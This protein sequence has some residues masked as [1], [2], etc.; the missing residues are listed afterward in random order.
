[1]GTFRVAPSVCSDDAFY[2]FTIARNAIRGF[3]FSFDRIAETNGFH[4]LWLSLILPIQAFV[5]DRILAIH[6]TLTLSALVDTTTIYILWKLLRERGVRQVVCEISCGLYA[7]AP[8]L[9]SHAGPMSGLETPLNLMMISYYLVLYSRA[10][11]FESWSVKQAA[12]FG[13]CSALLFLTRTDNGIL[14][15]ITYAHIGFQHRKQM[16]S[17]MHL[18]AS[19]LAALVLVAP[20]LA[21]SFVRFG[22]FV[23]VSGLSIAYVMRANLE[24]QGW[25]LADYFMQAFRN[26][27]GIVTF[28]PFYFYDTK[29]TSLLPL[30]LAS[31]IG[32]FIVSTLWH[33]TSNC[34]G[35]LSKLSPHVGLIAPLLAVIIAYVFV[36]TFRGVYLR[37]W[38]YT[39]FYPVLI[40]LTGSFVELSVKT[41]TK[42]QLRNISIVSAVLALFFYAESLGRV[43]AKERGER[44]KYQMVTSLNETLPENT[45]IGSWNAGVYGYFFDR[46]NVVNLDGLVNN[47]GFENIKRRTLK[48]YCRSVGISYL[49]DPAV[50]FR[51]WRPF[52][53]DAA[54]DLIREGDVLVRLQSQNVEDGIVLLK[55]TRDP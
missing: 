51:Y 20:W 37:G 17:L 9:F 14:L 39:S 36:H 30:L 43:L 28:F 44:D 27:A 41:L 10:L 31:A 42:I 35:V 29:L 25:I 23:Q 18:S 46:G 33:K 38:Y 21:W 11:N 13:I 34:R 19:A 6:V 5:N 53:N 12:I 15:I 50:S 48:D 1:M 4:P 40:L 52:W 32:A 47:I 8:I 49:V 55:L 7:F 24:T 3:G 2:Y 16:R 45:T 26:L 22:S 54:T